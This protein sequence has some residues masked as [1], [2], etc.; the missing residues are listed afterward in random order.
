MMGGADPHCGGGPDTAPAW[1]VD[2]RPAVR[3]PTAL[4]QKAIGVQMPG[5]ERGAG[6]VHLL[7]FLF[8]RWGLGAAEGQE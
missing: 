3:G 6:G 8:C 7:T 2:A 4:G 5:A 1:R